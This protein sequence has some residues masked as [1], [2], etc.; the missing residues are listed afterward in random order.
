MASSGCR[1]Q[2]RTLCLGGTHFST[3]GAFLRAIEVQ[4]LDHAYGK[5]DWFTTLGYLSHSW[6]DHD[7]RCTQPR[8]AQFPQEMRS[9]LLR[10]EPLSR[11]LHRG[12]IQ[13]AVNGKGSLRQEG[14]CLPQGLYRAGIGRRKNY[15]NIRIKELPSSSPAPSMVAP[16]D[17]GFTTLYNGVIWMA[18]WFPRAAKTIGGPKIETRLRWEKSGRDQAFVDSGI[19]S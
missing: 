8:I 1:R 3:R 17:Q 14:M 12:V 11:N 19:V 6:V 4:I 10:V 15:R 13:L 7:P 5:S 9:R 16:L 2:C 18:G